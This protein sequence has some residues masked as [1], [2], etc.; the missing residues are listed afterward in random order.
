MSYDAAD[1]R[2]WT[3]RTHDEILETDD[4]LRKKYDIRNRPKKELNLLE[5]VKK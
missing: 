4:I 1:P 2:Y 5:S 3:G